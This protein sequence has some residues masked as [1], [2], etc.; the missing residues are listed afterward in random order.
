M[1][2]ILAVALQK[3]GVIPKKKA[4]FPN[5][6]SARTNKKDASHKGVVKDEEDGNENETITTLR[7]R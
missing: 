5:K 3:L 2:N 1:T 7:V 4:S 6:T